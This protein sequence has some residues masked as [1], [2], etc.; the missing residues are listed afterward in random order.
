MNPTH[1]KTTPK[2]VEGAVLRKNNH[3][4]TSN[5]WNTVQQDVIIDVEKPGKGYKHFLKKRD[6]I[7]F[8]ELIPEWEI[9]SQGLDAIVLTSSDIDC[10]GYYDNQ[11]VVC[12]SA[13]EKEQDLRLSKSYYADHAALFSRLGIKSSKVNK[14]YLCE[15][16]VDQ[17][18]AYQLLH[19]LLHE[20]GHHFDRMQTKSKY[21][22]AR[23]E[24]FAEEY[25]YR[26]E[27]QI[28]FDY[29][30]AFEVIF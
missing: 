5:Y 6:V 13:W 25:A 19:I 27:K 17:I 1:R 15:F 29:Q 11:G 20:L 2:V 16:S 4:L 3:V 8:I 18:K 7:Q 23:G 28:W 9:I 30:T 26:I 14:G 12:I 22:S 21:C 24:N 10:D